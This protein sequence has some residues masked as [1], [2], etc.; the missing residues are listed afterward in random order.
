MSRLWKIIGW[1]MLVIAA[2]PVGSPLFG[3][4]GIAYAQRGPHH[5]EYLD[6]RYHHDRYYPAHG[7]YYATLP[8]GH[9]VVV[10]G[11]HRFF[12]HDGVWFR[13][14]GPR[15]VVIAPPFGVV[16]PILPPVYAT[17]VI[18]GVPYYYA[19]AVYYVQ[20]PGGYMVTEPPP[21]AAPPVA[22]A[23]VQPAP[24][25][26]TFI[27]PRKGQSQQQQAADQYECHRWAVGQTAFDPTQPSAS[28][29]D[30]QKRSD[31]QRAMGACLDARG[32]TVK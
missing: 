24:A 22:A 5:G 1:T 17:V 7:R 21:G 19:N 11:G 27:Y 12:F 16:V 25:D 4:E 14:E 13:A 30:P 6:S 28:G 15:F 26:R 31:Y 29:A 9:R 8:P 3:L 10:Y 18:G 23:P 32:Y 2:V 20:A